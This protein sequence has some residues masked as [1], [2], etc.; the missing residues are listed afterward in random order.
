MRSRF[1]T[2]VNLALLCLAFLWPRGAEA[3]NDPL[4]PDDRA[5]AGAAVEEVPRVYVGQIILVGNQSLPQSVILQRLP[6]SSGAPFSAD[7][8]RRAER[9]LADLNLFEVNGRDDRTP[10][11]A[12]LNPESKGES[13]DILVSVR[14]K[15][16]ARLQWH[17]AVGL[18]AASA[19][20]LT[21][22]PAGVAEALRD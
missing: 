2:V 10:S 9:S 4:A 5:P 19:A 12:V 14:E 1:R 22:L 20:W 7:H 13:R 16:T 21:G 3:W 18:R 6:L 15:P 11:V 17:I 8:L